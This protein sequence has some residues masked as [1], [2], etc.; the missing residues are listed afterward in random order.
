MRRFNH[1][2]RVATLVAA[3]VLACTSQTPAADMAMDEEVVVFEET[4]PG[5]SFA[6]APYFWMA[7]MEGDIAE[8]GAPPVNVDISFSDILDSL[9]FS[10]MAVAEARYDRFSVFSDF[11]FLK[12]SPEAVTPFGVIANTVQ[13]T[14]KT[15]EFTAMAGYALID[16]P[17]GRLDVVAGARVWWVENRISV[18]GG[19]LNGLWRQDS[20]AWV[21]AMAGVR[22]RANLTDNVYLTGWAL[23]GGG[24]SDSAWDVMGGVGYEF[25]DRFSA[26]LGYRAMGVDYQDGAFLFD[27]TMQGPIVGAVLRF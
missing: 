22:G 24:S 25:T 12:M 3:L 20:N 4:A 23:G 1:G 5:W 18:Q 14:S 21:D 13:L 19:V 26:V 9:D 2:A 15:M 17:G 16:T 27:V 7:G 6:I 11:L 10:L 8:F